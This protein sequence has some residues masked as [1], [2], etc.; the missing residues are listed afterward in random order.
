MP[1]ADKRW[2][3]TD[4]PQNEATL[5]LKFQAFDEGSQPTKRAGG[6]ENR[7]MTIIETR[8]PQSFGSHI[9]YQN[10]VNSPSYMSRLLV[11][12]VSRYNYHITMDTLNREIKAVIALIDAAIGKLSFLL[13]N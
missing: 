8:H 10:K 9:D 4:C 5:T 13:K 7:P 6:S 3:C 2:A 11:K 12:R 1:P